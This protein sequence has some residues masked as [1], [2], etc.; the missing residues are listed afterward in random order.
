MINQFFL[1]KNLSY[2][3]KREGLTQKELSKVLGSDNESVYRHYEKAIVP[4]IHKLKV[5]ADFYKVSVDDLCYKDLSR[6]V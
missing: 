1:H 4:N 6:N 5:I 2:L 3:R